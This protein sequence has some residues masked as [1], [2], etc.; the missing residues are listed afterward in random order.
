MVGLVSAVT[1]NLGTVFEPSNGGS[2]YT[3]AQ[4]ESNKITVDADRL[5]INL[6][7]NENLAL[8]NNGTEGNLTVNNL[9]SFNQVFINNQT[10]PLIENI[11][12]F[13]LTFHSGNASFVFSYLT[14]SQPTFSSIALTVTDMSYTFSGNVLTI[15]C[16]GTGNTVTTN[17]EV[18][19]GTHSFYS[20]TKDGVLQGFSSTDDFTI[21]DC[22]IHTFQGATPPLSFLSRISSVILRSGLAVFLAIFILISLSIPLVRFNELNWDTKQWINYFIISIISIFLII[23][24]IEQIFNV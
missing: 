11:E 6:T 7:T 12:A 2:F 4:F 15:G 23:I 5:T 3:L 17:M 14:A 22:S 16:T 18:L 10:T 8:K 24:L 21:T 20:H 19:K 13:N 9:G 1:T